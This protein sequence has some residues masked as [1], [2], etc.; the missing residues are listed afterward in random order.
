MQK[1]FYELVEKVVMEKGLCLYDMDYFPGSGELR[2]FIYSS[3]TKTA[4]IEDCMAIDR[5]LTP[6]IDSLDWMPEKLTLE[7]SSPGIYRSLKSIEHF[8][9]AVGE[10]VCLNLNAAGKKE[11][12][13][14]NKKL[15]GELFSYDNKGIEV[16]FEGRKLKLPYEYLK[17]ANVEAKI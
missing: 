2:V 10:L 1:K 4:Q 8:D 6:Y 13:L 12:E 14:K 9:L 11:V 3:E 17:S 7:V 5:A 16:D 15:V